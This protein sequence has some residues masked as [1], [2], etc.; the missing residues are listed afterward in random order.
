M[1]RARLSRI[2]LHTIITLWVLYCLCIG[3]SEDHPSSERVSW[4]NVTEAMHN[5]AIRKPVTATFSCT[6]KLSSLLKTPPS[7]GH[8]SPMLTLIVLL[9]SGDIQT[10]PG[11]R[12]RQVDTFPC[13]YCQLHVGWEAS[14]I[15]CD[16]CDTWFHRSCADLS[17]SAYNQ[18]SNISASWTCYRCNC[19]NQSS[20]RF[21]SYEIDT[22]NFFD[23]LST[24]S[25]HTTNRTQSV[26]SLA[27]HF[28]PTTFS[29]P[30]RGSCTTG[31]QGSQYSR[32][33]SRATVSP[34]GTSCSGPRS[35][36][37]QPAPKNNLRVIVAN[38]NSVASKSAELANV[39]DY[40]EPDI[41]LL[42][43][44]K[45]DNR[46]S[47]SEFLP[48]GYTCASRHDRNR[49][50][51][52]IMIMTRS[53]LQVENIAIEDVSCE[54][55]WASVTLADNKKLVVG[56]FYRQPNN[57]T[58]QVEQ[59]ELAIEQVTHK[60][61]NNNNITYI[62]GGD[63][64]TGDIDWDRATVTPDSDQRTV[65]Q[66]VLDLSQYDLTQVHRSPTRESNLLDLFFTNK[67][68]LVKSSISIPGISDHEIVLTDCSIKPLINKQQPR[69]IH[70]WK[71]TDWDKLKT[72]AVKFKESFLSLAGSWSVTE[73]F[74]SFKSFIDQL[75]SKHVPTRLLRANTKHLPWITQA[76]RRMC[77]RKQ[78][79]FSKAK[80]SHKSKDWA[81]YKNAKKETL[82]TIRRAH[83]N[84]INK[85]LLEGLEERDSKPFWRYIKF[86]K[87][88]SVGIAPIKQGGALHTDAN[89]VRVDPEPL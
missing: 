50:G 27:S 61:R 36:C 7:D 67:P 86:R 6:R 87:Q 12:Q 33:L 59:L 48:Q 23:P 83:W 19:I 62:L 38:C 11:P 21:H 41:L 57:S 68:G 78:R 58:E 37:I 73:N 25:D 52:G 74:N 46:V 49:S 56:V 30:T 9:L 88:D 26:S 31:H 53:S 60:F 66:R 82:R 79:L 32:L 29:T 69:R 17:T 63:F 18:L 76:I 14:G 10:N 84:Y 77:K 8:Q 5:L 24:L 22:S 70:L 39:V 75:T 65:N 89:I 15:A 85:I 13:G 34:A 42:T 55:T 16:G 54:T 3:H 35:P 20:R 43:E 72:E 80:R 1:R 81:E 44:T 64:N 71:R 40:T 45:L 47:S 4:D 2:S 51:G 28:S